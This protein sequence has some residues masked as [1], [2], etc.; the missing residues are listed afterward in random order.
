MTSMKATE[1]D[2]KELKLRIQDKKVLLGTEQVSKALKMGK[3]SK[4]YF[5]RNCEAQA[6][7]SLEHYAS[8]ENV[9]VLELEFS[10]EELGVFCKKNFFVSV[11]GIIG[12]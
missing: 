2:V 1:E 6:R 8:L 9:P 11:L 4:I 3:V 5:A 12:E 10:N 7:E